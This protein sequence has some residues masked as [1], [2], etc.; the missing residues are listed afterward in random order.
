MNIYKCRVCHRD[1]LAVNDTIY[2]ETLWI[3]ADSPETA[4]IAAKGLTRGI[5]Q[6][7]YN[8]DVELYIAPKP[9]YSYTAAKAKLEFGSR[10]YD[11]NKAEYQF[12][13]RA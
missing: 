12:C 6:T 10:F 1:C 2:N 3:E 7:V 9:R 8:P 13:H 5:D 11:H 4:Y